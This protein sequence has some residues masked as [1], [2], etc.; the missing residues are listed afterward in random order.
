MLKLFKG[1]VASI[2]LINLTFAVPAEEPDQWKN[3]LSELL[4]STATIQVGRATFS[5]FIWDIYQSQLSTSSGVYPD[6]EG[7]IVYQIKYLKSI[8]S[9]QLIKKT[10][11]QWVH[12]GFASERYSSYLEQLRNMWPDIKEGDQLAFVAQGNNSAFYY[13]ERF[14]GQIDGKDF[15]NIF[16]AIW[17]S[18][19]TSQPELRDTLLGIKS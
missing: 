13:N 18:E 7:V 12:L 1:L 15:R 9:K 10:I 16:M 14:I 11:E 5:V 17:F 6:P 4:K 19:N 3:S 2:L 8:E